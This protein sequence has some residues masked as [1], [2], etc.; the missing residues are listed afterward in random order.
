MELLLYTVTHDSAFVSFSMPTNAANTTLTA[1][2]DEEAYELTTDRLGRSCYAL[3]QNLEPDS[4]YTLSVKDASGESVL[5]IGNV[6]TLSE[7]DIS[8]SCGDYAIEATSFTAYFTPYNAED[9]QFFVFLNETEASLSITG[10][11]YTISA[12]DL[13][14][15]TMYLLRIFAQRVGDPTGG[16]SANNEDPILVYQDVFYTLPIG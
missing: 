12:S 1:F 10:D 3:F 7:P 15:E 13:D 14:P 5:F 2:L 6:N 16:N 11:D 9:Y 4:F 8:L